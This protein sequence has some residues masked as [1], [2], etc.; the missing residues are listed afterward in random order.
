LE[1]R[2]GELRNVAALIT[3][4]GNVR[5]YCKSHLPVLGVDRFVSPGEELPV[6]DT[7]V[8]RI[9]ILICYE[10]RFPEVARVL[11]LKGAQILAGP[12]CWPEGARVISELLIPAR[13]A[14]NRVWIV[15]ASRVGSDGKGDYIGKS[16][17]LDPEGKTVAQLADTEA[18]LTAD[19]DPGAASGK[20]L[21]RKPGE[22]EIDLF[23]DR[24]P[25]LYPLIAESKK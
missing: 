2:N 21:V 14:E 17:I 3:P 20:L 10:W 1:K 22:Y 13:A 15:S 12:T 16:A 24:K 5:T 6:F 4:D 9:G 8:G 25:E 7:P 11:A 19:I 18:V 23:A